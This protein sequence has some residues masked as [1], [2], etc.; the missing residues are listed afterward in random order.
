MRDHALQQDG[1]AWRGGER[2]GVVVVVRALRNRNP[3]GDLLACACN[4]SCRTECIIDCSV[5]IENWNPGR[6][7]VYSWALRETDDNDAVTTA[8]SGPAAG[9][10]VGAGGGESGKRRTTGRAAHHASSAALH[11]ASDA[12]G[13]GPRSG[14]QRHQKEAG[15]CCCRHYFLFLYIYIIKIIK[16]RCHYWPARNIRVSNLDKGIC[17]SSCFACSH[18]AVSMYI[19]FS[20]FFVF[21]IFQFVLIQLFLNNGCGIRGNAQCACM[22]TKPGGVFISSEQLNLLQPNLVSWFI[23][24]SWSVVK[25]LDCC[26]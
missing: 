26:V 4:A 12:R 2:D 17:L 16:I 14:L 22:R 21:L 3:R 24:T 7:R 8:I 10:E 13:Q 25:R 5:A 20:S 19:Q 9:H 11:T 18:I 6:K 1:H 23:T 15:E